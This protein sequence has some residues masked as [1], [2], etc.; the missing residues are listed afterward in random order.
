M[1][2]HVLIIEP[3]RTPTLDRGLGGPALCPSLGGLLLGAQALL[4][5]GMVDLQ[6]RARHAGGRVRRALVGVGLYDLGR[7]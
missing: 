1:D 6:Q 7:R 4:S 2:G 3:I 5:V